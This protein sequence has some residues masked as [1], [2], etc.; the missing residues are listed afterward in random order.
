MMDTFSCCPCP[1]NNVHISPSP[2]FTMFTCPH[3]H[4]SQCPHVTSPVS[5]CLLDLLSIN[6]RVHIICF[7]APLSPMSYC[8]SVILSTYPQSTCPLVPL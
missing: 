4:I 5:T 8:P 7:F 6:S 1:A 3:V 2:L